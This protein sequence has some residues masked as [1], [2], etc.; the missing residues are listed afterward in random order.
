M[1]S[2]FPVPDL[3]ID[4]TTPAVAVV[5]T[6]P[7]AAGAAITGERKT[8]LYCGFGC[9]V[10]TATTILDSL[11]LVLLL[12][13]IFAFGILGLGSFWVDLYFGFGGGWGILMVLKVVMSMIF[14][15]LGIMGAA[16]LNE[17]LVGTVAVW[18]CFEVVPN[19]FIYWWPLATL[20]LVMIPYPHI[21]LCRALRKGNIT[22]EN[23]KV[24]EAYCCGPSYGP[25]CCGPSC[26]C[27]P[28][29]Y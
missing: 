7:N 15:I 10:V 4:N 5:N 2:C 29:C 11:Y 16:L 18:M 12:V 23:Y 24:R 14:S 26:G 3:N 1:E 17:C 9:D 13:L 8:A 27:G 6:T 25:V 20:Y 19:F 28:G 22:P 21:A